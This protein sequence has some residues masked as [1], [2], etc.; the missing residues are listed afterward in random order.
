ML[1]KL[2]DTLPYFRGWYCIDDLETGERLYGPSK[3][4]GYVGLTIDRYFTKINQTGKRG[5]DG[6]KTEKE[7]NR[8]FEKVDNSSAAFF[9]LSNELTVLCN[10]FGKIPSR[11]HHIHRLK[12]DAVSTAGDRMDERERRVVDFICNIYAA[13]SVEGQKRIQQ[14]V[15]GL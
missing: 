6:R 12:P 9:D 14:Q 10:R 11:A 7:L 5:L 15:I 2:I 3:L 8:W 1:Q 4:I 13:L